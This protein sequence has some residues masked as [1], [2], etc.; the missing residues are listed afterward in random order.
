MHCSIASSNIYPKQLPYPPTMT[1][2]SLSPN[3][4]QQQLEGRYLPLGNL[5]IKQLVP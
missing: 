4:F 3:L 1:E 2:V 5:C